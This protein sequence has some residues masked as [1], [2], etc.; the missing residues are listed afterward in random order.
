MARRERAALLGGAVLLL[1]PLVASAWD[2]DYVL[3]LGYGYSDN[4]GRRTVDEVSG[5]TFRPTFSF[6]LTEQ[7]DSVQASATG[8]LSYSYY[9]GDTD[10]QPNF[11]VDGGAHVTWSLVPSRMLWTFDDYASQQPIEQFATQSPS[12]TQVTNVFATGPTFLFRLSEASGARSELRYVNSYAEE[13]DDFNSD[14][15]IAT[16][17]FL[18]RINPLSTISVNAGAEIVRLEA[19]DENTPDFDRY[20][21]FGSWSRVSGDD[22]LTVDLGWNWV[23]PDGFDTRDG[24]LARING[25]YRIT[26]ISTID[27]A[28]AHQLMDEAGSLLGRAND[29]DA[30][31][32]PVTSGSAFN[33][34]TITADVFEQDRIDGGYQLDGAR[35]TWRVSGY[36]T[37]QDYRDNSALSR[38]TLGTA[39]L[40]DYRVTRLQSLGAFAVATRQRFDDSDLEY[41]ETEFGLRWRYSILRNLAI[42]LEVAR[43]SRD[44]NAPL[45]DYEETRVWAELSWSRPRG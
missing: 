8:R 42:S 14:R 10:F 38:N 41:D 28:F 26:Q 6:T 17:Q 37:S 33:T 44:S 29:V 3:G 36:L 22:S 16:V 35:S 13:G 1:A 20:P 32:L 11:G 25:L 2:L 7:G 12:N 5:N 27:F 18:R 9:T 24:L 39:L 43:A 19:P 15:G 31:L 45:D 21:V 4:L 23:D 40:F 34:G 30:L